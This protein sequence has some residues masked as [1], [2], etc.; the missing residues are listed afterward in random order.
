[1]ATRDKILR[2]LI[3]AADRD[4]LN[5]VFREHRLDLL[6]GGPK[7][8]EGGAVSVQA[9]VPEEQVK[10][11]KTYRVK[12]DIL[13]ADAAASGRARQRQFGKGNR[14][15]GKNRVPRGLGRKIRE[16]GRGLS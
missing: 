6:G 9:L 13:D 15:A 2:I 14:F 5:E 3:T 1:M 11:L 10:R 16:G 4:A 8:G 7:Q 12:I